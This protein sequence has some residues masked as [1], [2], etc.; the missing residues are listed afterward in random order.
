[1]PVE[2]CPICGG[3]VQQR[4]ADFNHHYRGIPIELSEIPYQVC[5]EC[6]EEFV[7]SRYGKIIEESIDQYRKFKK[8]EYNDLLTC[9]EVA[10][11]LAVS[12]QVVITM[13]SD[14]KLP[15]T[16]IGREWRIPYG[17]LMDYIQSMSA[18]NLSQPEKEI[19]QAYLDLLKKKGK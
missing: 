11:L 1:M 2:K 12:Y 4:L 19:Y 14:G 17:V 8:Y 6:G 13:L 10:A 18:H 15:G 7:D 3:T 5:T 9:E 16:K